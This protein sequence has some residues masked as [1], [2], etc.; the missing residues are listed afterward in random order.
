VRG[1][2]VDVLCVESEIPYR[3]HEEDKATIELLASY[4][5]IA[6]QNMQMQERA[7]D[8]DDAAPGARERFEP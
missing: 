1:E 2:L 4:L 6:I 7:A 5:A 3:F 8:A